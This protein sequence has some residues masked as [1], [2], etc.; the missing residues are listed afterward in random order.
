MKNL[1]FTLAKAQEYHRSGNI[2]KSESLYRKILQFEPGNPIAQNNLAV[3]LINTDRAEEAEKILL[4]TFQKNSRYADSIANMAA[5][6]GHLQR[7]EPCIAWCKRAIGIHQSNPMPHLWHARATAKVFNRD[8]GIE[9][10]SEAIRAHHIQEKDVLIIE[11]ILSHLRAEKFSRA[12]RETRRHYFKCT[13]RAKLLKE[14][15]DT[16]KQ[17]GKSRHFFRCARYVFRQTQKHPEINFWLAKDYLL[18]ENTLEEEAIE[19][20]LSTVRMQPRHSDAWL[21]LGV[22]LKQQ[23]NLQ[24]ATACLQR[25]TKENPQNLPAWIELVN[26]HLE[27]GEQTVA[28]KESAKL[29]SLFPLQSE[30]VAVHCHA[31]IGG[32][33]WITALRILESFRM[34]Y[35]GQVDRSILNCEGSAYTRAGNY[36]KAIKVFREA[37]RNFGND[38]A[39]WNNRGMAYGLS[40]RP[41]PEIYCYRKAI[42]ILP[43]DPGSH[44]NLAMARLAQ[45]DYRQGLEEYEWRL[46]DKNGAL[47]AIPTGWIL[48]A[49]EKP[50]H[51]VVISEQGLGDTI[52]FS[53]YLYDLR[54]LLPNTEI[55]L[56]CPE[57]LQKPIKT[58]IECIDRVVSC[59]GLTLKDDATPYLPLMSLP[60]FCSIHP[61]ESRAPSIYLKSNDQL[62]ENAKALLKEGTKEESPIIG[63]NWRGNPKTERTNLK[64]RSMTLE[65]LS[66]LADIL[67]NATFVSLQK[68]A[69]SEEL[70]KCTF[71][72]RFI[73]NQDIVSADWCFMNTSAYI[74][75]C[76]QIVTT[77]TS[78]AHLAGA[79]GQS[80]HLLL[81][82]KPEW[83]WCMSGNTS[84]WYQLMTIT[85][86]K[87]SGDWQYPVRMAAEKIKRCLAKNGMQ[88]AG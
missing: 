73:K 27:Q 18:R 60:H 87:Q 65:S 36:P 17:A 58:S 54:A 12:L 79:L 21:E 4:N 47:N 45:G 7:W 53:R 35:P 11:L 16:S 14:V 20:L 76:D 6:Q 28:I 41:R 75:A 83:R 64:G 77:D 30:A 8:K 82:A 63:L 24:K 67:P 34:T 70:A 31:L 68:G 61:H 42:R 69:G 32:D 57:K 49:G 19:I 86:Q 52:Q 80:T 50:E 2:I 43:D 59:E 5:C 88:A 26:S 46:K 13:D 66:I 37:V 38:A 81:S 3:I 84:K 74:L 22:I 9:I 39:V 23:K 44:V 78:I 29:R 40:N 55:T 62:I 48:E 72:K 71:G 25:A 10:L 15:Y 1:E 51:L 56:A 85:R 33:K